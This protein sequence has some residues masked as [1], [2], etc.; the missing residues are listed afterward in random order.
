[1]GE[2]VRIPDECK[3]LAQLV[4]AREAD[5]RQARNDLL[6]AKAAL[7]RFKEGDTVM[8]RVDVRGRDRAWR[9]C[10]V[11]RVSVTRLMD[12]RHYSIGYLVLP[13]L[14]N[15]KTAKRGQFAAD[16]NIK[17]YEEGEAS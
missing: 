9:K 1:M 13:V 4:T 10:K 2:V 15:G 8:A 11:H 5:L 7:A 12:K 17:P 16:D 6:E 14:A 3:R